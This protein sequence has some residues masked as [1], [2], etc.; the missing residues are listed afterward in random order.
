MRAPGSDVIA[1]LFC[2]GASVSDLS[3]KFRTSPDV[4]ESAIRRQLNKARKR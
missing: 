3:Y 2:D 1:R 4:I